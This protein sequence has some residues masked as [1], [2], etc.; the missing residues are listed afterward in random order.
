MDDF[1]KENI[2]DIQIK[3]NDKIKE[4]NVTNEMETSF[5]SYAM[6]VI[7]A[8]ALPDVRDGLKPVHRRI[9]YGMDELGLTP[10]KSYKKS[11]RIVGDVMGKYHPHGDS[12][13]YDAMVRMA[14]DF[15][16]RYP[17]VNGHGN[18]G[19]IDGDP[20]AAM[21]YTEA[22]MDKIASEILKD[23]KKDT[24]DFIENYDGSETEPKVLPSRIPNLLVNG[25]TGIAVGMAT[26]IPPHNLSEVIDGYTAYIKD[27]DIDIDDLMEYIKGP[28]FPTGGVILGQSGI[29][30]AYKTGRG[31]IRVKAK[32]E[33]KE[34]ANGKKQIIIT[35]IPYQVNKTTLIDRIAQLAKDKKIE[36]I[37]DLRDESSRKGMR[38]VIE[39]RKD[40]NPEVLLNN[41]YKNSQLQVSFGANM[42]ALV[43]DKPVVLNLKDMIK[44]YYLHQVEVLVRKTNF[45]LNKAKDRLH[46]LEGYIIALNNIDEVIKII[47]DSYDDTE[48]RLI[49]AFNLS[50]KQVKEI[51]KMQLRRLSGLE[52]SKIEDEINELNLTINDLQETLASKE[53]QNQI[54]IDDANDIKSR[55]GDQRRTEIDLFGD[56]DIDDEDLIPVEDVIIAITTN[57]YVKRMNID[58]YR[59]QNRGGRGKTGMQLNEDD[60]ID[61]IIFTSTHDYLLFFTTLGRVYK[62]KG[63]KIPN[64]GRT[65]KGLPIVNLLDLNEGEELA[66]CMTLKDF[67]EGY[68]FFTTSNGIVKRT[69]VQDFKN[70]RANGIRAINLKDQDTLHSVK[71]TDGTRDIII[72]AS[73]GKA[74]RFHEEQVRSMGRTASGVKGIDLVKDE[75][76]VGVTV[77]SEDQN[78]VLAITKLGYGKRTEVDEYRSQNRGGK[79]VKTINV[80]DKNGPLAKLVSV[81]GDEDLL[82]VS[83]Q[84]MIIRTPIEQISISKRATQGVKIINLMDEQF[85]KTIAL[86]AKEEDEV[87]VI[88]DT[89]ENPK[90]NIE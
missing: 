76:V 72:G 75:S 22:K 1:N 44:Y 20:A 60:V 28:D 10:D 23:L 51:L 65:S 8:R 25:A 3:T 13:I 84:G 85:V 74:I 87:E 80:T 15:S 62:M 34:L 9:L 30:Q 54:L 41:L 68:L 40:I 33:I 82:V 24:V 12:A 17:L 59:A 81:I 35:E 6:S 48:E 86:I 36:G 2:D 50:D 11:A 69:S 5:L 29:V 39:L 77:V 70:I 4:I 18:F 90:E 37:T 31:I 52:R 27:N 47:R 7:V 43:D 66:T 67:E 63:Y 89:N 71:F 83:N 53:K 19:S 79:G 21:R 16:Y 78:Q 45:D 26:N 49:Q 88:Q 14:Q 57:G 73:N 46:I 55:F 42:L 56:Y 58:V 38:I 61:S 64:F 32:S